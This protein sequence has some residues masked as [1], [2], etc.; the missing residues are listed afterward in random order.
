MISSHCENVSLKSRNPGASSV[1]SPVGQSG[2]YSFPDYH[3]CDDDDDY[4]NGDDDDVDQCGND[5][6]DD[7]EKKPA[8]VH[9]F[10]LNT[11]SLVEAV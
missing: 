9:S 6:D 1:A 4:D 3:D 5:N 10:E 2:A 7:D 8:R 11:V